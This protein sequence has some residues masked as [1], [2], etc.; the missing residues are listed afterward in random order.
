MTIKYLKA[1][2]SRTEVF[3]A[4]PLKHCMESFFTL[5]RPDSIS[6]Y[7][8]IILICSFLYVTI[9]DNCSFVLRAAKLLISHFLNWTFFPSQYDFWMVKEGKL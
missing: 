2:Q 4:S 9:D 7:L 3:I 5:S 6:A 1:T 8:Q